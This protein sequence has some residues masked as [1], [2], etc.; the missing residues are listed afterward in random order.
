MEEIKRTE[1]EQLASAPKAFTSIHKSSI[2]D[3]EA[4]K[5]ILSFK[6]TFG[7]RQFAWEDMPT[8]LLHGVTHLS[9]FQKYSGPLKKQILIEALVSLCPS[10]AV[11]ILIPPFIDMIYSLDKA[12]LV[13]KTGRGYGCKCILL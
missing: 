9:Q 5:V 3:Q 11:D 13:A 12:R 6:H 8:L 4:K 10:D 1:G 2:V 7:D